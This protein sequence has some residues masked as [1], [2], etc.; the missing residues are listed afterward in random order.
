M[1]QDATW[2]V[3]P[4]R[5]TGGFKPHRGSAG[6]GPGYGR[7][8]DGVKRPGGLMTAASPSAVFPEPRCTDA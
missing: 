8:K 6:T 2:R 3:G 1:R 5:R 7:C 4:T